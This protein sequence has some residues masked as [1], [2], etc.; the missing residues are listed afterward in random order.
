VSKLATD[1]SLNFPGV[2]SCLVGMHSVDVLHENLGIV[3]GELNEK[4]QKVRE[5]IMRR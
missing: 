2:H 5:R 1:Y 4:E 3:H